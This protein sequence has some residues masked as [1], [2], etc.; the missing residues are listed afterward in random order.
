MATLLQI[1]RGRRGWLLAACAAVLLA[2]AGGVRVAASWAGAATITAPAEIPTSEATRGDLIDTVELRGEI[3]AVRSVFLTAPS[4]AGDI[5]IVRLAKNGAAI[6]KGDTVIQFDTTTLETTLAQR[7][8][9]L[10]QA[11]AQVEDTRA[12]AKL[13]EEQ[14]QTDLLT[15]KY[16]ADKAKLEASK[17]EILSEIDGQE[18]RLLLA[19]GEQKLKQTEEKLEADR[20]GGRADLTSIQQKSAKAERDV[21]QYEDRIAHMVLRA[22]VDGTFNLMPNYRAGGVF[23]DSAPEFREGDRAWAGA[24]IAELPDMSSLTLNAR[25]DETDRGRLQSGQTVTAHVDAVPDTE[26]AGKVIS[27]SPLAKP[28]Y[29][30]W[31]P[32]KNFDLTVQLDHPD[33]RLRPGMSATARIAVQRFPNVI[34]VPTEAV[35]AKNGRTVVYVVQGGARSDKFAETV[36]TIGHRGSGQTEVLSGLKTGQRVALKDPAASNP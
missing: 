7:R 10:K 35:F 1:W 2:V 11:D 34:L 21:Q 18:K 4:N 26:P 30:S 27:I 12:K 5:Q 24:E 36:V 19:D 29:T 32:T 17:A 13:A 16:A 22:P 8:S 31:P 6:H 25:V 9:D 23:G 33:P 20:Q 28:D 3:K 14:D 15:A